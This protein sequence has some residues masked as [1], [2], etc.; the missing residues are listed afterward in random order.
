MISSVMNG[1]AADRCVVRYSSKIHISV[2]LVHV[3]LGSPLD[4]KQ[5]LTWM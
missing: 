3:G 2:V 4:P 1:K 5:E